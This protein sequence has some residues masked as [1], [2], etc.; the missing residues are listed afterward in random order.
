MALELASLFFL[1]PRRIFFRL[2]FFSLPLVDSFKVIS[3][4][5]RT[6]KSAFLSPILFYFPIKT[7]G[8]SNSVYPVSFE[9]PYQKN[10]RSVHFGAGIMLKK[11][12]FKNFFFSRKVEKWSFFFPGPKSLSEKVRTSQKPSHHGQKKKS[13]VF[14]MRP[15]IVHAFSNIPFLHSCDG[16]QTGH[17]TPERHQN[18]KKPNGRP[19]FGPPKTVPPWTEKKKV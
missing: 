15:R 10:Y 2:F 1:F 8:T 18:P 19:T 5:N 17:G 9:C 6:Q 4:P 13:F 14:S 12:F 16:V 3:H 7:I 11:Q